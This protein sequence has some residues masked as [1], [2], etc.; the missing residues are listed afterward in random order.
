MGKLQQTVCHRTFPVI[1]MGN[2]AE[3][4]DVLHSGAKVIIIFIFAGNQSRDSMNPKTPHSIPDLTSQIRRDIVRMVT[5]PQKRSPG[6]F[7]A[8]V[9]IFLPFCLPSF[10]TRIGL[11]GVATA[12]TR[13][14]SSFPSGTFR[15]CIYSPG[16][17]VIFGQRIG[18]IRP[19]GS[20]LQGHPSVE[21]G[22]PEFT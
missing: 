18:L 19:L 8:E 12:K 7:L 16:V 14:C 2:Y 13:I 9:P 15:R 17:W 5:R 21:N 6:W 3:I 20:R 1:Y 10:W 22:L 4:S 11:N